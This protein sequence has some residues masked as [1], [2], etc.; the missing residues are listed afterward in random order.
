MIRFFWMRFWCPERP[1][2]KLGFYYCR[3]L[4]YCALH[5]FSVFWAKFHPARL[6]SGLHGCLIFVKYPP[7]M[8]IRVGTLIRDSRVFCHTLHLGWLRNKCHHVPQNILPFCFGL[9]FA[10]CWLNSSNKMCKDKPPMQTRAN[11]TIQCWSTPFY[12]IKNCLTGKILL[13]RIDHPTKK[14]HLSPLGGASTANKTAASSLLVIICVYA[15]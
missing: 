3:R 10:E 13:T 9:Y 15:I 12:R 8:L 4:S 14:F 2:E 7:C 5:S 11:V 6:Y 1:Y